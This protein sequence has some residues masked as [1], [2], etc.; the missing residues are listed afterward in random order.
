[1]K[2]KYQSPTSTIVSLCAEESMMFVV[3][4][5]SS[6]PDQWSNKQDAPAEGWNSSNWSD[7]GSEEE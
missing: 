4:S 7:T 3:G 1:M 6:T 2:Q 5:N